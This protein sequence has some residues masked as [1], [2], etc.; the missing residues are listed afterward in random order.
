M[1]GQQ[2]PLSSN[3]RY[4]ETADAKPFLASVRIGLFLP[5]FDL[6]ERKNDNEQGPTERRAS[7]VS[8]IMGAVLPTWNTVACLFASSF[9]GQ[10]A[11]TH[12]VD[13]ME[14]RRKVDNR[15]KVVSGREVG[16]PTHRFARAL[17]QEGAQSCL[18]KSKTSS[19]GRAVTC[20]NGTRA[21]LMA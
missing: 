1:S 9:V 13:Q 4:S 15:G 11:S 17:L 20:R 3:L 12:G 8:E 2:Q 19:H 14:G 10:A 21:K 7:P 18:E 5:A 6:P 16:V